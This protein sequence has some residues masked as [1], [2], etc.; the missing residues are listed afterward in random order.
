MIY[1][2]INDINKIKEFYNEYGYVIIDNIISEYEIHKIMKTIYKKKFISRKQDLWRVNPFIKK[3]AKNNNILYLLKELY[4]DDPLPFQTLNFSKGTE[5]PEHVDL[6]HFCPSEDNLELMCG[7]WIALEDITENMGP[8]IFY[9]KS[10]KLPY[11]IDFDKF[12]NKYSNYI[13][14]IKELIKKNNL[15]SELGIIKKGSIIIWNSNLIH[16][17]SNIIDIKSTRY[18]MVTHYFF[19]GSKYWWTPKISNKDKKVYRDKIKKKSQKI[20]L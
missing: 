7:V 4:N 11:Y 12:N 6:V 1:F 10:H 15:K 17:G 2:N 18:S 16:G 19:K 14:F 8:L 13:T 3:V 9:P 5:Q 20:L